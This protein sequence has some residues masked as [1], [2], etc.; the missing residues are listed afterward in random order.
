MCCRPQDADVTFKTDQLEVVI[1]GATGLMDKYAVA[2]TDY[3]R[4]N[5]FRPV[6]MNDNEDPGQQ[7]SCI[8]AT[9]RARSR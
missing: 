5:A 2:G 6:V 1:N 8:S 3:L 9:W 7:K 4:P